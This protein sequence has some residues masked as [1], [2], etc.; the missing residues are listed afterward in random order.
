MTFGN[1]KG[2]LEIR[3]Y[4]KIVFFHAS[5]GTVGVRFCL[6]RHENLALRDALLSMANGT[7]KSNKKQ[8]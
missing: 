1:D 3:K 7:S 4:S 6:P 5:G 2:P 8:V